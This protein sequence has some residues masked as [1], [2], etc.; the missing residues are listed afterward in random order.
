VSGAYQPPSQFREFR[1]L[2]SCGSIWHLSGEC[3]PSAYDGLGVDIEWPCADC[4]GQFSARIPSNARRETI[5]AEKWRGVPFTILNIRNDTDE[6]LVLC[7]EPWANEFPI[8]PRTTYALHVIGVPHIEGST[9]EFSSGRVTV[10]PD[11]KGFELRDGDEV[12]Y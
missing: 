9:I 10:W 4:S 2:C 12:I 1:A 3:D 5:V 6:D 8:P 7:I 11:A